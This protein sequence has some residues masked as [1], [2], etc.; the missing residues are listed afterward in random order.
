[1]TTSPSPELVP[2]VQNIRAADLTI[3]DP[4]EIG[5]PA[6]WIPT[7]DLERLLDEGLRGLSLAGLPLRTR[8]KVAKEHVCRVLGYPVPASF[9]RSRPRFPG[10][11]FDTYVQ[12]A[13]NLQVWN[14]ELSPTRRY[15]FIRP[16]PDGVVTTVKVVNGNAL[17]QLDTTG[18]LTQKYQA[19]CILGASMTELIVSEDTALLSPFVASEVDL[20]HVA[21]PIGYP[22]AGALLP[23]AALYARLSRL[24]GSTF[25]DTGYDQERN[26]GAG[27]H[28]MVCAA[29]GY[30]GYQDDGQF[31]DVRHQL[32][33]VKLQTSPTIDLGL[34]LPSSTD[35][36]DVP[37][38]A[39]QQVRHCDVRY[40]VFYGHTDGELVTLT[41]LFLTTGE[42]FFT[43]FTQFQGR[44][45]N[46]KLQ[47][48]LPVDF[49]GNN[50]EGFPDELI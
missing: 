16:S 42:A 19:R 40:A 18:T 25:P 11:I 17:A 22:T 46:R 32:L 4:I 48:S 34:V 14:E 31:P 30:A 43:R 15:V 21:T 35:L 38:I 27:L 37:Q 1:M 39:G 12:K 23:I 26:R 8:S 5:D 45:L 13:N 44:V 29:L 50:A 20:Q 3:Y 47:I 36:L 10:Q 28:R 24:I 33:E 41:H 2:Y 6:L 7:L 49:F 9:R